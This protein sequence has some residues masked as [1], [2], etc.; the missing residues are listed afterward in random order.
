M[1]AVFFSQKIRQ[2][3]K[4]FHQRTFLCLEDFC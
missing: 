4:L 2:A 3:R 1:W